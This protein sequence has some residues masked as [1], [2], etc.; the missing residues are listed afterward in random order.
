MKR[1]GMLLAACHVALFACLVGGVARQSAALPHVWMRAE[2]DSPYTHPQRQG[3]YVW[4]ALIVP[5]CAPGFAGGLVELSIE[6]ESVTC[7]PADRGINTYLTLAK[8][9]RLWKPYQVELDRDPGG[10]EQIWVE[11]ALP[12]NGLPRPVRAE[13]RPASPS[14]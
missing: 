5:D 3:R 6:N 9:F 7:R 4:V 13:I 14:E 1:N 11:V 8:R 12:K 2:L 10:Q